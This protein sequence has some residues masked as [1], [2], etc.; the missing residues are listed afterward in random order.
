MT[1]PPGGATDAR[2]EPDPVG[3]LRRWEAA[4]AV[5]RVLARRP[6][7]VDVALLTC[8]AGEE[9]ARLSSADAALLEYVGDREAS[10]S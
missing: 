3:V 10:D 2:D 9:V 4:G 1:R 6:G 8:D 5:W 7:S